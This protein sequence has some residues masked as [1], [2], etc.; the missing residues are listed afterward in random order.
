MTLG[1]RCVTVNV[2]H[3]KDPVAGPRCSRE[4]IDPSWAVFPG[5]GG[6]ALGTIHFLDG[7]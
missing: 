1:A 6:E 5:E 2:S 4:H 3:R 7:E